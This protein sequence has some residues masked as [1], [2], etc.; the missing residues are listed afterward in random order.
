MTVRNYLFVASAWLLLAAAAC[1]DD[2]SA[3][4][5]CPLGSLE[6]DGVCIDVQSD[7]DHCGSCL[8]GC[9]DGLVCIDA[10]CGSGC[11]ADALFCDGECVDVS[12]D[13]NNCA[14]CGNVCSDEEVCTVGGCASDCVTGTTQCGNVCVDTDADDDHCGDCNMSCT[15]MQTCVAGMCS[16]TVYTSCLDL[17]NDNSALGSGTY[18][19]DPDGSGP[20]ESLEVYCDMVTDGGGYSWIRMD[21]DALRNDQDAYA[22][23]CADIGMEVV[24]MRTRE[25]A[26]ALRTYNGNRRMNLVNVFPQYDGAAG[27]DNWE[28]ICQGTPCSFWMTNSDTVACNAYE[29]NGDNTV[30]YRLFRRGGGC[31][32][33]GDWNDQNNFVQ[34]TGWVYCSANDK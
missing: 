32:L 2:E 25:H 18:R 12:V 16:D 27:I 15:S 33:K 7:K 13:R 24:V 31:G 22:Q 26:Q 30:S 20:V 11:V 29:P 10:E 9:G 14:G 28:G 17:L 1:D 19:I 3:A 4:V 21:N 5:G 8:L 34:I 6:C 23:V